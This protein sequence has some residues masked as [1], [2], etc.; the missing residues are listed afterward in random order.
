MPA[1]G[2]PLSLWAS[3]MIAGESPQPAAVS[4]ESRI[5]FRRT[6]PP[7]PAASPISPG[8]TAQ[9]TSAAAAASPLASIQRA[10]RATPAVATSS[11][12]TVGAVRLVPRISV[13]NSAVQ[14]GS[15]LVTGATTD[16]L[17]AR[18]A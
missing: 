2:P 7:R 12:A 3:S 8:A 16:A 13:A 6:P 5:T 10:T 18:S 17:P 14:I 15:V 4:I 1:L 9:P 11:P